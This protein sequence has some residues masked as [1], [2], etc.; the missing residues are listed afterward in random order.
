MTL[1]DDPDDH[2][3]DPAGPRTG[4]CVRWA[5]GDPGRRPG[6]RL[7]RRAPGARRR[8]PDDAR[9]PGHRAHRPVGLRQ[10]D[11]PAHPQP[12]ARAGARRQPGRR[13]AARRRATSTTR[14]GARSRAVAGSAWCSRSRTRSRRCRSTT[15]CSRAS[16]LTGRKPRQTPTTLV[17][18]QP[19][20]RR[21]V[22]RGAGTGSTHPA[23]SLSGG[24]Q[25]RL[26]IA[27]ALAVSPDVLLMDEP[28]S[29]LDP[30]ST[31]RVEET[32]AGDRRR[33]H[34]RDR[35]PQHAAGPARLRPLRVLPRRARTSPA[36]SSSRA[37][38]TRSSSVRSDARTAD[39]VNGRFG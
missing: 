21:P 13:G 26:C 7:V 20:Q 3:P 9:R 29:A 17:E 32:I 12:D 24:Q 23:A 8:H 38:P 22:E 39:Y 14:R 4:R 16:K 25:Q 18:Q 15:T 30:T 34:D 1:I 11:V 37:R 6:E 31:R 28:C 35:H 19:A 27:R 33:G 5:P 2:T 36:T 10:V